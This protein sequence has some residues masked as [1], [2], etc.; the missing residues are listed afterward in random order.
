MRPKH[1]G[2]SQIQADVVRSYSAVLSI[3]VSMYY[4]SDL[5][6]R[7]VV[8]DINPDFMTYFGVW[9]HHIPL[10]RLSEDFLYFLFNR[11]AVF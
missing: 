6:S 9:K 11:L 10:V 7:A 3:C 4:L 2:N 8:L 1:V 5:I